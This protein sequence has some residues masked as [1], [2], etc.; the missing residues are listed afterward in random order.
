MSSLV[1]GSLLGAL[2]LKD[3]K[4]YAY[5]FFWM[6]L[7]VLA[8]SLTFWFTYKPLVLIE[9]DIIEDD[10]PVLEQEG[11]RDLKSYM[12][13][14]SNHQMLTTEKHNYNSEERLIDREEFKKL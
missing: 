8:T 9:H 10:K 13:G 7:L 11:L 14:T 12:S 5:L 1:V 6:S 3:G 2:F 4:R